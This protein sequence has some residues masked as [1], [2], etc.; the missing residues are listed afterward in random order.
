MKLRIALTV[1]LA[2]L[3]AVGSAPADGATAAL[4][5]LEAL[6]GTWQTE[7]P[8]GKPARTTYELV[9][10]GSALVERVEAGTEPSMVTVY[11]RDGDGLA[12]THYCGLGNQPRMRA[13][14]ADGKVFEFAFV[15]ATNL[16]GPEA[17]H[18]RTLKMTLVDADHM[19]QDWTFS[20]AGKQE[21]HSFHYRRV[22]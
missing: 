14:S 19:T 17:P 12:L 2:T 1:T 20:Q 6:V 15:D 21:V 8:D 10:G 9:S 18:M 3:A 5:G 11:H 16:A 4:G 7:T 13:A 22:K